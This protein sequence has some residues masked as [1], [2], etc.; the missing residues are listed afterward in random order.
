MGELNK[1]LGTIA[2]VLEDLQRRA[3]DRSPAPPVAQ[4]PFQTPASLALPSFDPE[5]TDS[6][7]WLSKIDGFKDEFRWSDRE[8]VS[9]VGPFLL[10]SAQ[11]WFT[12]WRPA[13]ETWANFKLDFTVSFPRQK[14]LGK[15]LADAV[16]YRS[17]DA[18][19]YVEIAKVKL[20]KLKS[21]R[22]SWSD[23]D[24]IEIIAHSVDDNAMRTAAYN[25]GTS[26]VSDLIAFLANYVKIPLEPQ[27]VRNETTPRKRTF[28]QRSPSVS[29]QITCFS[30]GK[31][32]H[33]ARDCVN[34]R[35]DAPAKNQETDH[36]CRYVL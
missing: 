24:F 14:N 23:T 13:D 4:L 17:T 12:A 35:F 10:K 28:S 21:L 36:A 25:S 33:M 1:S 30:C 20:E 11:R 32:G 34:K 18:R 5:N 3:S 6:S 26:S 19:S 29:K 16:N 31:I 22:A 27:V 9:R 15:L 8:T 7:V 2:T